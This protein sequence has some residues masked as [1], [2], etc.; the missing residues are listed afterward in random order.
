MSVIARRESGTVEAAPARSR[1]LRASRGETARPAAA[2]GVL[3]PTPAARPPRRLARTRGNLH[4]SG[5]PRAP[6]TRRA[7]HR[8]RCFFSCQGTLENSSPA[9]PS[10]LLRCDLIGQNTSVFFCSTCCQKTPVCDPDTPVAPLP[11]AH[12]PRPP[13]LESLYF[14]V[15]LK[16][17]A[18]GHTSFVSKS[19]SE[20]GIPTMI[21]MIIWGLNIAKQICRTAWY[22][23]APRGAS[24]QLKRQDELTREQICVYRDNGRY[25][26]GGRGQVT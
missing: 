2:V 19:P 22:T 9:R 13:P 4:A 25:V 6:R 5:G 17:S 26:G 12:T 20:I 7:R 8:G 3:R 10:R 23:L 14:L 1:N 16:S 21:I 24:W 18:E 15:Y 11:R